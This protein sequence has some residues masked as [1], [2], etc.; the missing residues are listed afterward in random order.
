[1]DYILFY[2]IKIQYSIFILF[3]LSLDAWNVDSN[4]AAFMRNIS[5]LKHQV[6]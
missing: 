4:S 1:M 6:V 3:F 5:I 2:A